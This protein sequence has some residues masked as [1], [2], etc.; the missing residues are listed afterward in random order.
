MTPICI[1]HYR[2]PEGL[3]KCKASI[4]NQTIPCQPVVWDNSENNIGLTKAVNLLF[5]KVESEYAIWLNHDAV[6]APDCVE[7]AIVFMDAHPFAAIA[8]MKQIDPDNPDSITHGGTGALFP[9]GEHIQGK[10]SDGAC[11]QSRQFTWVNM[12][13]CIIRMKAFRDIGPF[14]ERFFLL[15]QDSD[16]CLRAWFAGWQVWYCAD[17]VVYHGTS[18]VSRNPTP[19]Q[20]VICQKDMATFAD[21]WGQPDPLQANKS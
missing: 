15:A 4:F 2:N 17:A 18:G 19:E 7:Q 10:V 21:K 8:G 13:A 16:Y 1:V 20:L 9:A 11:T 14:D 12:A 3:A 5:S 6:L